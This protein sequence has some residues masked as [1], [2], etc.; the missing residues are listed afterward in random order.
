M[1]SQDVKTV[2]LV[3]NSDQAQAKLAAINQKLDIARQ[4]RE[5][6]FENGDAKGLQVYTREIKNLERQAERLGTRAQAVERTLSGLDRATP[7]DLKNTIREINKELNSGNVE[8]NSE[9]WKALTASLAA[10]KNELARIAAEQ[11]SAESNLEG[12]T[13]KARLFGQQWVGFTTVA[14]QAANAV[15]SAMNAMKGYVND[16]ADMQ[17]HMANVTKYTGLSTEAVDE[18]N[19]SFKK[20]E[21]RTPREK[22]NDLASDA[23]RLGINTKEGVQEFVEAADIINTALGEDLGEDA[24]KNIGKLA[25]MFGESDRLG[26]RGAMLAT[27]SVINELAQSSSAAEGYIM[28]FANRLGGVGNQAGLS[29]AQIMAFGSVLDQNAV[30]VEKGAT[31][32]QNV[33]TALFKDPAKMAQAAGLEVQKFTQLLSTDANEAIIQWLQA[34]QD[35]GGMAK[36]APILADMNLSGAG[37]TQTLTTLAG[38]LQDVKDAQEQANQAYEQGTSCTDEA[39]KANSTVQAR[40]EQAEKKWKDLRVELG[41]RLLPVYTAGITATNTLVTATMAVLNAVGKVVRFIVEYR[42]AITSCAVAIA[43]FTATINAA[44]IAHKAH[45]AWLAI[46]SAAK[47]AYTAVTTAATAAMTAFNAAVKSNGFTAIASVI[48]SAVAALSTWLFM[49]KDSTSEQKNNT[50]ANEENAKSLDAVAEARKN[51]L[52]KTAEERTKI[53]L[54]SSAVH[55]NALSYDE[56]RAALDKLKAI[57]PDY[58]AILTR[59]GTLERDNVSAINDYIS[60]LDRKAMAEAA[61][62]KLVELKKQQLTLTDTR[63]RKQNN[64]NAVDRVLNSGNLRYIS[65]K[66]PDDDP[67]GGGRETN[68]SRLAKLNERATQERALGE[69]QSALDENL[70]EQKKLEEVIRKNG[71]VNTVITNSNGA[72]YTGRTAHGTS[73]STAA[74]TT[75][76]SAGI[77]KE[78]E[79]A[80]DKA[81]QQQRTNALLAYAKGETDYME[82][83]NA[84]QRIDQELI[85]DKRDLYAQDSSE[86]SK[87]NDELTKLAETQAAQRNAWSISD[88]N[89]QEKEDLSAAKERHALGLAS[90]EAYEEQKHVIAVQYLEKRKNLYAQFGDGEN[91]QKTADEL[92]DTL[93]SARIAK[94]E[95]Y[96]QQL[97]SLR[98]KYA[99]SSAEERKAAE[100]AM[101]DAVYRATDEKGESLK[102]ISDEEYT[103]LRRQIETATDSAEKFKDVLGAPSDPFS[104]SIIS[105]AQAVQNLHDKLKEGTATWQDYASVGLAASSTISAGLSQASSLVQANSQLEQAEITKRYDAEIEA[106]GES[107]AKGKKLEEQKQ[108]ELASVKNKYNKRQMAIEI[109]QA[110]VDGA[111]NAIKAYGSMLSIPVVGPALGA[112][113]AA[114]SLA[115][116]GIQIATI[117]KQHDAEAA[118]YYEGGFTGGN[119]YRTEAGIVHQGEF[120]ANHSAVN[121]PNVRPVLQLID[122]A[123]RTNRIASLTAADVSR[124]IAAPMATASNTA[125][126]VPAVQVI[127]TANERTSQTLDR[128]S[129]QIDEGIA[130][131][132]TIDG[133]DGLDRQWRRYNKMKQQ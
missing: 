115:F 49:T 1:N 119:S 110:V 120:V 33:I 63:D 62:E 10:A 132:V 117:K 130:A 82:Y 41:K 15:M 30:S 78:R 81:A 13:G 72:A 96:E 44:T 70:S 26:L 4:K 34:L 83:R 101:L 42:A 79:T 76:T 59:E 108:K 97:Q 37:V 92:D 32:L 123:Q 124:A 14:N 95:R 133:P 93:Q 24:V 90:D 17:E 131:V 51:A 126:T 60:A 9:E 80:L 52:E 116:S 35:T 55:N 31:A 23:G 113:A 53:D 112:A 61:Y 127:N 6:A 8:R 121:N 2:T 91:Y 73:G 98:K 5:A 99:E 21:T 75:A 84:L 109:A 114:A 71:G 65:I 77:D 40:L 88:L 102:L 69:A 27:G 89:R 85:T 58:H 46:V 11:R 48:L 64:V 56:R 111:Q 125:A 50:K 100:L 38:K 104:S 39:A 28:E 57:I 18:L 86:W 107:T 12:A 103:N 105:I 3:I 122:Y 29:Q 74:S 118:G 129:A 45:A 43:T 54:L 19:E 25:Q 16:Y 22:L 20:L 68:K 87:H 47:T 67:Y 106:A 66:A 7:K 36:L 94:A 128:L